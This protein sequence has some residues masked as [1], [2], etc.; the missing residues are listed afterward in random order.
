[1]YGPKVGG[2]GL[3]RY[4]EQMV[5]HLARLPS[6]HRFVLFLKRENFDA[7]KIENPRFEKRLVDVHW[8]T[9]EEQRR[10]PGIVDRERLD[11]MHYPHWNIPLASR[12]PFVVTIHDLILLEEPRSAK[13]STHHPLVLS[14][15]FAA[16]RLVLSQALHRAKR[17]IAVSEYCRAS[18][19]RF[20]PNVPDAKITMI[21]EGVTPI[22]TDAS[23]PLPPGMREPYLLR[24][25]NFYPHK[26]V[27]GLLRAFVEMHRARPDLQLVLAGADDVFFTRMQTYAK[28]L[29]LPPESVVFVGR[30]DDTVLGALYAHALIA[31]TPARIEGFGLP[32]LEAMSAGVATAV[33]R[34]GSLPEVCGAASV[35]FDA[36]NEAEM[37]RVLV[38]LAD[39]ETARQTLIAN[40]REQ[41]KKFSWETMAKEILK[42][43]E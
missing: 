15:K 25:G 8:Y 38:K 10:M 5:T 4:V 17:V 22:A 33:S 39:N 27:D 29:A 24:V 32:P 26:N 7:C 36:N 14:A 21:H 42:C 31:V 35:Y 37:A 43:Y 3:G 18:I 41:I 19:R 30:P 13:I 2:G 23:A 34:S 11:L 28:S 20:F 12:T 40:G 6:D 9:F 1:M 16:Y